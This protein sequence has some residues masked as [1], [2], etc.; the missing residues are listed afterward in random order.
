[1][2]W[3][4]NPAF[5]GQSLEFSRGDPSPWG[6]RVPELAVQKTELLGMKAAL[7]QD[8]LRSADSL[9]ERAPAG[10]LQAQIQD[11]KVHA[12]FLPFLLLSTEPLPMSM[13]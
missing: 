2:Y 4:D 7:E 3:Q 1:M 11:T 9:P 13:Y 8:I 10:Q 12:P 6:S 5:L